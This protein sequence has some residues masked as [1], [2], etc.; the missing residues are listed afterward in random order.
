MITE[1]KFV[2]F[3]RGHIRDNVVLSHYRNCLRVRTNPETGILFTED[4]I[5]RATQPGSMFYIWADAIDLAGQTEQARALLLSDQQRPSHSNS[6]YLN[7]VHGRLWLGPNSNLAATGGS[8]TVD[9]PATEYTIF[10]G[11]PTL[12]DPTAAVATDPNGKRYQ[13]LVSVTTPSSG[14]AE[15]AMQGIDTGTDTNPLND[16]I[17]TWSLNKPLGAG[18]E[19]TVNCEFPALGFSGGYNEETDAEYADRIESVMRHRPAAGNPAQFEAWARA[20]SVSIEGAFI[21]PIFAHAGSVLV[22][23]TQKRGS[24]IG[25]YGRTDVSVG[26]MSAV[27]RYLVPPNSPVVPRRVFVVVTE[28]NPQ[29]ADLVLRLAMGTGMSGGWADVTPWPNPDQ[30]LTSYTSVE[31]THVTSQTSFEVT[32]DDPLPGGG[33]LLTGANAP[34][35]MLWDEAHSVF[36]DLDVLS[37]QETGSDIYTVILNTAPSTMTIALGQRLSPYTDRQATISDAI[38]DYFDQLGPGE[39][40]DL[41]TDSRSNRCFRFP[42]MNERYSAR[43]GQKIVSFLIDALG[44]TASDCSLDE[45]SRNDPGL[46]G[47]IIDGPNIITLG[48]V[49]LFPLE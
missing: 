30:T 20:A 14:I 25:P 16:T 22:C 8:G 15:L 43:A 13:V 31:V 34:S 7:D 49:N 1:R 9:A 24:M 3:T 29:D 32:T 44:D 21:Y 11:S 40:I 48:H 12:G 10:V 46:P 37:V 27:T 36:V 18:L 42:P 26:N 41:T 28:A 5:Q 33:T 38:Q 2:T 35:L 17:L 39:L 47:H 19:A 6:T 23:V 45:I 4:E